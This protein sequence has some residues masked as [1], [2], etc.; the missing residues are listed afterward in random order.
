MFETHPH[1]HPHRKKAPWYDETGKQ[2][3]G[4]QKGINTPPPQ[5]QLRWQRVAGKTA[6]SAG[7]VKKS[8]LDQLRAERQ[9]VLRSRFPCLGTCR[10]SR[11]PVTSRLTS[12][13][14]EG[15]GREER[16]GT[17]PPRKTF[18]TGCALP[19]A[20]PRG[21]HV[22]DNSHEEAPIHNYE[23]LFPHIEPAAPGKKEKRGESPSLKG[24]SFLPAFLINS[25]AIL[26]FRPRQP[27][28]ELWAD[29]AAAGT[30]QK[31]SDHPLQLSGPVA[32]LE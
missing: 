14:L 23:C 5:L 32:T 27:P 29:P 20:H 9:G 31:P 21:G 16:G 26:Q 30:R 13:Q 6:G 18:G 22:F 19:W 17:S 4:K 2:W 24:T 25:L 12:Q 10:K 11:H 3:S 1:P 28:G 7:E 15:T 8:S